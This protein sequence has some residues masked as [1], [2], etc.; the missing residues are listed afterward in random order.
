MLQ[1]NGRMIVILMKHG[2]FLDKN[3]GIVY[4]IIRSYYSKYFGL[5]R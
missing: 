4:R 1:I 2:I 5:S 3:V